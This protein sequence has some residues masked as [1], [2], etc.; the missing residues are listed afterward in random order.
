MYRYSNK[1]DG[2]HANVSWC[3]SYDGMLFFSSMAMMMGGGLELELDGAGEETIPNVLTDPG[4]PIQCNAND[5]GSG[6]N[7]A[8]YRY[9]GEDKLRIRIHPSRILGT[10]TGQQPSKKLIVLV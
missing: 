6:V 10:Q 2:G 8:V 5:V 4:T 3:W 9:M 1:K 7:A